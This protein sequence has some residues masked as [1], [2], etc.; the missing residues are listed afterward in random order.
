MSAASRAALRALPIQQTAQLG[1]Q[2]SDETPEPE[3][4]SLDIWTADDLIRRI[5]VDVPER[6]ATYEYYDFNLPV[7]IAVPP[8]F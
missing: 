8:G 6:T 7:T 3:L 5:T 1:V 4:T 2:Q